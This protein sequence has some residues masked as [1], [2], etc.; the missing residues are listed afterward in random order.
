M[1]KKW[2]KLFI[3]AIVGLLFFGIAYAQ[4][5]KPEAAIE[6]RQSVMTIIGHHVGDMGAMVTGKKPYEK[7]V[8]SRDAAIVETLSTLPWQA[9]MTPGSDKGKTSLKP[10][11]FKEKDQFLAKSKAFETEARKLAEAAS[12]GGFNAIKAQFGNLGKSCKSCHDAYR[13]R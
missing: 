12:G 4:F 1:M 3:T 5:A 2:S 6:Y 10:S 13:S 7:Q 11:A 9:F 8:F